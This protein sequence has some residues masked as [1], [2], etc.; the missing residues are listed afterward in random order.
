MGAAH[1]GTTANLPAPDLGKSGA[2]GQLG[3]GIG[4]RV[5]IGVLVGLAILAGH[6]YL[7]RCQSGNLT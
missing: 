4:V 3:I 2:D 7:V 6:F 1:V 5:G